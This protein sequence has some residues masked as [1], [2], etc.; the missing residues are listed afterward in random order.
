MSRVVELYDVREE[1][2]SLPELSDFPGGRYRPG[3]GT[4]RLQVI[5][6]SLFGGKLNFSQV[7]LAANTILKITLMRVSIGD[8]DFESRF[9]QTGH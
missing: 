6:T 7:I 8:Y 3:R 9:S 2:C 4:V 1:S 5:G